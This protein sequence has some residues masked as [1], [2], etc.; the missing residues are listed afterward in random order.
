ML[1]TVSIHDFFG[2]GQQVVD[3]DLRRHDDLPRTDVSMVRSAGIN[4][5]VRWYYRAPMCQ[6][7]GPLVLIPSQH[8]RPKINYSIAVDWD[9]P[10]VFPKLVHAV[11]ETLASPAAQH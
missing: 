1:T 6:W 3:A 5:Q 7:L 8:N 10:T 11:I 9:R 4:S 2:S